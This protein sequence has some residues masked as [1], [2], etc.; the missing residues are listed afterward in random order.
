M[1][2]HKDHKMEIC[3]VSNHAFLRT[4][5]GGDLGGARPIVVSFKGN[6]GSV[7]GKKWTG[8]PWHGGSGK[9]PSLPAN[10]NNYFSLAVFHTDEAGKF[11]RLK[12][13]FHSLYAVMLDD[14]GSKVA[15]ERL[16]LAP[17]WQLETSAG[18]YQV[19]YLLRE[20]L[21]DSV[22]TD[23]LMN[24]IVSAGLCDP[25]AN[26]PR[27][28][29][30]R[31]PVAVNGKYDP[32]YQCRLIV[33]SPDLRYSIDELRDGF[34]LDMTSQPARQDRQERPG[35]DDLI[36]TPCPEENAV[37]AVLHKA[38]LYKA[39]LRD[40]K[41]DITCPWVHEHTDE[42]DGGTVYFE[43]DDNRP[44]GGFKCLHGHCTDRHI[45]DLLH[46][47]NIAPSAAR[48]KPTCPGRGGRTRTKER[49]GSP[50]ADPARLARH[51]CTA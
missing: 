17:S 51:F 4:V 19:G 27:T 50:V 9:S 21:T 25:G 6:P 20:P 1:T 23:R 12:V 48:M 39:V 11:R 37:L 13:H 2:R 36:W 5:F 18:N 45:N 44:I 16:T 42:I 8:G 14:V 32:P 24:A 43:P 46:S 15:A 47:L 31:L 41:H 26:G 49:A 28:R 29:L 7:P 34:E 40:G 30:A 10:A 38:G 35:E 33:W 3:S 22:I